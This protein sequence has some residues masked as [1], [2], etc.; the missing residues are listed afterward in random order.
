M[1]NSTATAAAEAKASAVN[2]M[3]LLRQQNNEKTAKFFAA[4]MAGIMV[5]FIIFHWT[6]VVFKG[7]ERRSGGNVTFLKFPIRVTRSYILLIVPR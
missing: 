7:Y 2:L 3:K 5:L 6:R 4:A 1:P